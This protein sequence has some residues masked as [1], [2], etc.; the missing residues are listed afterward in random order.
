MLRL[1]LPHRRVAGVVCLLVLL[2]LPKAL[3][4]Q[5]TTGVL[6]GTV[7]D[8]QHEVIPNARIDAVNHA[9]GAEFIGYSDGSG[10]YTLG[11]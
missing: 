10:N 11:D 2:V 8:P 4:G 6:G 5:A 7:Y 3:L 1:A 9:T